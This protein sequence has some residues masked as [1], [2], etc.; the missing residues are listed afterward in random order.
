MTNKDKK[1]AVYGA[2]QRVLNKLS[3]KY[4][5]NS[6]DFGFEVGY[7]PD[8]FRF[9]IGLIPNIMEMGE[10]YTDYAVEI[11]DTL[12]QELMKSEI[13]GIRP[14][15]EEFFAADVEFDTEEFDDEY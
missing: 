10:D 5:Y 13:S 9:E 2:I 14:K 1:I 15:R 4:P 11:G 12:L 6:E 3:E 8:V 7:C